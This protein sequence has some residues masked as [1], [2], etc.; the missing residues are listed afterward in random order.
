MIAT[1]RLLYQGDNVHDQDDI[2]PT[3]GSS[4][5]HGYSDGYALRSILGAQYAFKNLMI[6]EVLQFALRITFRC[7]LHRGGSLDIHQ[8]LH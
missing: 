3:R 1:R 6:H 7:V 5:V 4:W 8:D 2:L